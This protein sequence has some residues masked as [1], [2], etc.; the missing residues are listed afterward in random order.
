MGEFSKPRLNGS[1]GVTISDSKGENKLWCYLN[2]QNHNEVGLILALVL[3]TK[4]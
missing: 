3:E 2:Q 4:R 1:I